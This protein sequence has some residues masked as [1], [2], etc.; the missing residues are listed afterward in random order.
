MHG[1]ITSGFNSEAHKSAFFEARDRFLAAGGPPKCNAFAKHAK[2]PETSQGATPIMSASALQSLNKVCATHI[3]SG[4][5]F[6][7]AI[8]QARRSIT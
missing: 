7:A 6:G 2:S 4:S 5:R 1:G 8:H 3:F